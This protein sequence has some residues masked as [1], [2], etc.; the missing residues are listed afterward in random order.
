MVRQ[1]SKEMDNLPGGIVVVDVGSTN[2]KVTLFDS[3]LNEIRSRTQGCTTAKV[4]YLHKVVDPILGFVAQAI[5]D[6]DRILPADKIVPCAHGSSLAL[7]DEGDGLA[8]PIM[9]YEAE[10]PDAVCRQ[11]D[12]ICPPFEEVLS[13]VN[14]GALTLARQLLWQETEFPDD[15][16]TVHTIVPLAQY[17]AMRLCGTKATEVTALGAQTHL[18]NPL[19]R[20]Y[21]KLARQRGWADLFAPIAHAWD[22]LGPVEDLKLRGR[23]EVLTGIH[24]SNANLLRYLGSGDFCLLSTGTWI[25]AF[26]TA[27]DV[28]TLQA[29]RDQ[30]SNTSIFGEP[31]ACCRFMGGREFEL[32]AQGA[33]PEQASMAATSALIDEKVMALPSFTDS[34]GP[35]PKTG[36]K[37]RICGALPDTPEA[38]ASLAS[39]YCAQMTAIALQAMNTRTS[40][41]VDGPFSTNE[42][43]LNVLSHLLKDCPVCS[44]TDKNGT[45]KGAAM[46]ALNHDGSLPALDNSLRQ[47]GQVPLSGIDSYHKLWMKNLAG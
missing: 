30:V 35:L 47:V 36:G 40:I 22:K 34:G 26:D 31:I 1:S 2:V 38:R 23:G 20:N 33:R 41:I 43:Y 19:R 39:L 5:E 29:E 17:I 3:A 6:F 8:M 4:P 9:S 15:F 14:P 28:R 21:S 32:I 42:V 7:L 24:D 37:G 10:I 12:K 13:P 11:Y 46:L 18:W 25:I 27:A 45:S 44:A 16:S